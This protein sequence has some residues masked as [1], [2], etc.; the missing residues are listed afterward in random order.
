MTLQAK[1]SHNANSNHKLEACH[2]LPFLSMKNSPDK[3]ALGAA[4]DCCCAV[5]SFHRNEPSTDDRVAAV[6]TKRRPP[7]FRV[8]IFWPCCIWPWGLLR[9]DPPGSWDW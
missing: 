3:E 6:V 7:T 9:A 8:T 2:T 4:A 1:R 5:T